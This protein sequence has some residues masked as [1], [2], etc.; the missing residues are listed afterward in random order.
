VEAAVTMLFSP[1]SKGRSL[2]ASIITAGI[3]GACAGNSDQVTDTR[4]IP[5]SIQFD[6][7]FASNNPS[8]VS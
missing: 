1:H 3:S 7:A 4:D 2:A 8:F 6:R 5:A